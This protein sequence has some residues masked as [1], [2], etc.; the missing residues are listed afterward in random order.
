MMKFEWLKNCIGDKTTDEEIM[1]IVLRIIANDQLELSQEKITLQ[2]DEYYRLARDT[3]RF[4]DERNTIS[5]V[6]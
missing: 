4:I 2:R 1:K 5:K 3:L 6:D